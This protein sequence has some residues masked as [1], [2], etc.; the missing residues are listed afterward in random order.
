[1][2]TPSAKGPTQNFYSSVRFVQASFAN[3]SKNFIKHLHKAHL[4]NNLVVMM[5]IL[6]VIIYR[7][8]KMARNLLRGVLWPLVIF[9]CEW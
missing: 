9:S 1:M 2:H 6:L 4:K 3:P 8:V 7:V 5:L